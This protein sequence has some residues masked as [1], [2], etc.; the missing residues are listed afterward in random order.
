MNAFEAQNQGYQTGPFATPQQQPYMYNPQMPQGAPMMNNPLTSEEKKLLSQEDNLFDLKVTPHEQAMAKCTHKDNG[1]FAIVADENGKATCKIC[2]AEF[3]PNSVDEEYVEKA[4]N[5][6][7]NVLNTCK[8][9][10]VDMNNEV[11]V[12]Y[13]S[14]IPYI[15][16]IPKLYKAVTKTFNRYGA[17]TQA[18]PTYVQNPIN[19]FNSLINPAVPIG[20]P[21]YAQPMYQTPYTAMQNNMVGGQS[22]FYQQPQQMA[23]QYGQPMYAQPQYAAPQYTQPQ[24]PQMQQPMNQPQMAPQAQPQQAAPQAQAPAQQNGEV[25]VSEKV[26]L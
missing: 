16:R 9:I 21:A 13:F 26:K 24:A 10:A 11:I 17:P 14:M 8:Y 7:L 23:P 5:M 4:T 3:Y 12:Q 20:A 6:I 19:Q 2:H 25:T 15:E 1:Q 18:T 22:V